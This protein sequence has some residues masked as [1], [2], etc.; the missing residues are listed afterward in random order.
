MGK[1]QWQ[2]SLSVG[3]ELIDKQHKQW[4]EYYNN[5]ADVVATSIAIR[6]L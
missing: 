5:T 2:D 1:V 6:R 4:I 3:I